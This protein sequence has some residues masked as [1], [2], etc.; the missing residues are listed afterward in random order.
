MY[1]NSKCFFDDA[2]EAFHASR[3]RKKANTVYVAPNGEKYYIQWEQL[4]QYKEEY[5][6]PVVFH[7]WKKYYIEGGYS[8]DELVEAGL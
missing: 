5:L 4:P 1:E 6:V 7:R 3:S 8:I 2:Y